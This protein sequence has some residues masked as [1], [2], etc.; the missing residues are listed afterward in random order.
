MNITKFFNICSIIIIGAMISLSQSD[1]RPKAVAAEKASY[2]GATQERVFKEL[3]VPD[4]ISASP[5]GSMELTYAKAG[6][7]DSEA[8]IRLHNGIVIWVAPEAKLSFKKVNQP[9]SGTYLGQSV[10]ELVSR[11]GQP[12]EISTGQLTT[13]ISYSNGLTVGLNHGIV[14]GT[15]KSK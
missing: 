11:L 15:Y 10:R 8:T 14:V 12:V 9:S 7:S 2:L 4:Q 3:G 5:H 6:N 1:S 13:Q